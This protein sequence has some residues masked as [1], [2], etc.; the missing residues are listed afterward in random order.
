MAELAASSFNGRRF[1]EEREADWRRL[2]GLVDKMERK[3]LAILSD[4]DLLAL[5]VLYRAALSSLSVA[6]E[7]S[8]D[9]ALIDYLESLCARAYFFVYGVRLPLSS[10]MGRF[11]LRDWPAAVRA[12]WLETLASCALLFIGILAGYVLVAQDPAWFYAI[13]PEDLADTR[14]PAASTESLRRTLYDGGDTNGLSFFATYLF[15]HNARVAIF[16]FALG[17]AFGVPTALLLVYFGG[18]VGAL[19]ALFAS[20]GLGEEVVGWLLIHGTTELFAIVLASAAGFRIGW[21]VAFPGDRSRL[22]AATAAGRQA[23]TAMAGVVLMLLVAGLLE[24]YGRQLITSDVQRYAIAAT[25]LAL[26][27]G[28]FYLPK[29]RPHG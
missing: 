9:R 18:T 25:M 3:S 22:A 28:Y 16:S 20:R 17:F 2:E 12:I 15:T 7:T 6:R 24:G 5:P 19:I 10:R 11:F 1:R 13:V 21:R 29:G 4:D 27:M 14:T 26:W 23:A 8:L